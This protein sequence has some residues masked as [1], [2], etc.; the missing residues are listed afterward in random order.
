MSKQVVCFL[1][2][3]AEFCRKHQTSFIHLQ[4]HP[5]SQ[6][7]T[8]GFAH[9]HTQGRDTI[10]NNNL[11]RKTSHTDFKHEQKVNC[12]WVR[13]SNYSDVFV[14]TKHDISGRSC[15]L[16]SAQVSPSLLPRGSQSLMVIPFY[17]A[18]TRN[19]ERLHHCLARVPPCFAC[20][21]LCC[22]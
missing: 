3:K 15:S 12:G 9:T 21:Q 17:R 20:H 19:S 5:Y 1:Q 7:L 14:V 13:T 4:S 11:L 2:G 16:L 22:M 8:E 6:L 18:L 10:D